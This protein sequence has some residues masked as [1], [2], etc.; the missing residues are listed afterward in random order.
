MMGAHSFRRMTP[1]PMLGDIKAGVGQSL[2]AGLKS[3][4]D[5]DFLAWSKEQAE[6]LRPA[7]RNGSNQRLDLRNLAEEI[8]DLGKSVRRGRIVRRLLKLEHSPASEPRRGR[9][10]SIVD[11]R[12]EIEDLPEAR[13][14][15]RTEL[16]RD[17]ERQTQRGIDLALRDLGC[18]QE[19]RRRNDGGDAGCLLYRRAGAWRLVPGGAAG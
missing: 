4:Y 3:L 6:A 10:E 11:A 8:E 15:L 1:I 16:A 18:H 5:T 17:V 12:A 13:P 14:S 19:N 2:M 9:T 7:M